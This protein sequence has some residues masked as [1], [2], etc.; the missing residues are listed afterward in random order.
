MRDLDAFYEQMFDLHKHENKDGVEDFVDLLLRLEKGETVLGND[1]LTRN[2]IKA[3][4]MVTIQN[5]Q[6]FHNHSRS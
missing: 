5:L 1:K 3:I 6:Y 4:L 2:H